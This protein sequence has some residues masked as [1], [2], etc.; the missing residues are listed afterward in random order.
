MARY[1][2]E[3][4]FTETTADERY[5][6]STYFTLA[7]VDNIIISNIVAKQYVGDTITF[8][9]YLNIVTKADNYLDIEIDQEDI[10]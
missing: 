7:P 1:L 5:L 3:T 2:H 6:H 8:D 10:L 9:D 4:Y